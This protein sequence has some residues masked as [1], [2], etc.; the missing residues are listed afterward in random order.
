MR[1]HNDLFTSC[2]FECFFDK[3]RLCL[4]YCVAVVTSAIA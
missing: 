2:M 4:V 1:M 3:G